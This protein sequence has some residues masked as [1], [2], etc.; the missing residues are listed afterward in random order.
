M[1]QIKNRNMSLKLAVSAVFIVSITIIHRCVGPPVTSKKQSTDSNNA[2]EKLEMLGIEYNR[3]LTQVVEVLESDP[4]FRKKLENAQEADIRSGK[5][6]EELDYV[7][8]HV[9]TKLDELK[10]QELERLRQIKKQMLFEQE[11]SLDPK[12]MK[13]AEHIDHANPHSFEIADLQKLIAKVT[14][15]LAEAD[16]QR[17]K[18]FQ[19]Y[20]MQKEFEKQE[21][22]KNMAEEEKKEYLK[23]L[24]A[25]EE[26]HK[27]HEPVHHPG[28][29]QQ[30]EEVWEKQDHMD[31]QEFDPKAFFYMHDLDGNGVWDQEEVNALF[32]K[33]LDKLYQQ[34]V[35]EDDMRERAEEMERMREHVFSEI[36]TNKDGL[37]SYEEFLAQTRKPEF[38]KDQG[39]ETLDQQQL[40]TP[41]EYAEFERKRQEEIERLIKEGK[42][43]RAPPQPHGVPQHP[44]FQPSPHAGYQVQPHPQYQVPQYQAPPQQQYQQPGQYQQQY[45]GQ[46]QPIY[47]DHG[48]PYGHPQPPQQNNMPQHQH[49]PPSNQVP[50]QQQ[51]A[52]QQQQVPVQQQEVNQQ[53]PPPHQQQQ[54]KQPVPQ[55]AHIPQQQ[56]PPVQTQQQQQAQP[57]QNNIPPPQP[58]SNNMPQQTAENSLPNI[59]KN[60]PQ[61]PSAN[62]I[63]QVKQVR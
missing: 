50:Y 11:N 8:H 19:E 35:P 56:Q 1:A 25:Q 53:V 17:R 33:E 5:I 22:L 13:I 21:K 27:K 24:E 23:Q 47:Q 15:D 54:Q 42:L 14:A 62:Q 29:K 18:E 10:R 60:I 61:S 49:Q 16:K 38:E 59:E 3:Y 2:T 36:D 30:L 46:Q 52:P 32:L 28:S 9:R 34:G 37:I 58:V 43:Q 20:E 57:V 55:A 48:Y 41:E 7:N 12:H 4:E 40:Y 45:Q 6:A 63:P 51:A 31:T 44:Q 26:K 39:W